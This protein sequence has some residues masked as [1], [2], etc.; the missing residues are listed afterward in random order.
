MAAKL[1][2]KEKFKTKHYRF[3]KLFSLGPLTST[4]IL[5]DPMHLA[6][7]LS[8]YKFCAKMLSAKKT[9]LEIGCGDA[10]GTPIV[11]KNCQKL[12]AVDIDPQLIASNKNRLA[13]I[14]NIEF[15]ELD[16]RREAPKGKYEGVF[17]IDVI[18]HLEPQF[19][20]IYFRHITACLGKDGICLT[21]TPNKTAEKYSSAVSRHYHV[22]LFDFESL[23]KITEKYFKN[24]LMFTM[25]DEVIQSGFGPMGH[26][27]F[28]VGIGPR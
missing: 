2:F 23:K 8:R 22:N 18:E 5:R 11:A 15:K 12:T 10:F 19:N 3:D 17:S 16:I 7:V 20:D 28:A 25:N 4:N 21:G 24:T 9:I 6:F 27:L 1:S 14:R 13:E 26:F